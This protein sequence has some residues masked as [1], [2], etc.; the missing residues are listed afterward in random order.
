MENSF[1][2]FAFNDVIIGNAG[3]D[4]LN[5]GLGADTLTG[6]LGADV[7]RFDSLLGDNNVDTITDFNL[8]E[9]DVIQLENTG[10]GLFTSITAMGSLAPAAFVIGASCTTAAQRIRYDS[11][12]GNLFYDSDGSGYASSILFARVS[13]GLLLSSSQFMIN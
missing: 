5:G 3:K 8:S 4:T 7:F 1:T 11:I 10:T 9:G 6:G 13:A 12:S 2:G